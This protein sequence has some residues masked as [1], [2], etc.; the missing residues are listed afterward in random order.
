MSD[1]PAGGCSQTEDSGAD[2]AKGESERERE[3]PAG[4]DVVD[5]VVFF[6][7][8]VPRMLAGAA[9]GEYGKGSAVSGYQEMDC[10]GDD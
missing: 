10:I 2:L 4:V 1:D 5:D 8:E 6:I 7:K 3:R 9:V